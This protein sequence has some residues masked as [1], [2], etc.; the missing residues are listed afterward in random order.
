VHQ[1]L[2]N[3]DGVWPPSLKRYGNVL[4]LQGGD[5]LAAVLLVGNWRTAPRRSG[6]LAHKHPPT[7]TATISATLAMVSIFWPTPR[8]PNASSEI[9]N[10]VPAIAVSAIFSRWSPV[11]SVDFGEIGRYVGITSIC[12][13]HIREAALI[14][15]PACRVW[16]A[17]ASLIPERSSDFCRYIGYPFPC[18]RAPILPSSEH[19]S[20]R[21][22]R[23]CAWRACPAASRWRPAS[24]SGA[25]LR[26]ARHCAWPRRSASSASASEELSGAYSQLAGAGGAGSRPSWL[27]PTARLRQQY[28]EKAALTERLSI[29]ARCATG[30]GGGAR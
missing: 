29:A 20:H 22:F 10:D 6:S 9:G 17:P 24:S 13:C 7:S 5:D 16:S 30:G 2:R 23:F 26:Q 3:Q 28:Q 12:S 15:P 4:L 18:L 21:A 19:M 1:R 8:R 27:R 14:F 11:Y 25:R